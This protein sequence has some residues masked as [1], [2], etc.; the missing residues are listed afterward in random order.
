MALIALGGNVPYNGLDSFALIRRAL[1]EIVSLGAP[2]LATSRFYATPAFP[3]GSGP[4]FVN[5][6]AAVSWSDSPENL[7]ELL[8]R[9]ESGFGRERNARWS[10]RT[11]DLDLLAL[12]DTV[13]PNAA[14]LG[15]WIALPADQQMTRTPDTLLLPH[16][17]LHERAFVLMPLADVAPEWRHPILGRTVAELLDALPMAEKQAIKPISAP[18]SGN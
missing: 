11:L 17:R 4:D 12:D 7:L 13:L 16:P 2:L 8:H 6:A 18:S 3:P 10:A 9:V 5:A 1:G 14:T 15:T